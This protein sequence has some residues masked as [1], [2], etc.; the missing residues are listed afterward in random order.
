VRQSVS[1]TVYTTI[2]YATAAVL[3]G[4]VCLAG[5]QPLAGW[6]T[7]TWVCLLA[8]T[9]GPQFLGHSVVNRVLRT[10]SAT[11]VSVAILFEIVGATLIAWVA[12]WEAPPAGAYPAAVLIAGGVVMVVLS[13]REPAVS[14]APV[15]E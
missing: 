12:F 9:A 10:T 11:V 6:D 5:G 15:V 13:G 7:R 2:C 14:G 3:L 8:L 4:V 1:T